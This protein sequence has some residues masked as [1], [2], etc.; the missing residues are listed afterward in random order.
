MSYKYRDDIATSDVAF[1][2]W[3][4]TSE[5]MFISA[6]DALMNV[7]VEDLA[8]IQETEHRQIMVHADAMDMLLY[9]LLEELIYFK[10]AE[11]LLLRVP[12]VS[13][14]REGESYLL[15]AEALGEEINPE[16]HSFGVDVKAVTLHRFQVERRD[17][18]WK[19]SV[20]LDI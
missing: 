6:A 7:Q 11:K 2:A 13:I 5:E 1:E 3:G 20:I 19:A 8:T 14:S 17:D 18:G 15:V 16:K 12:E 10:D 4:E 9:E